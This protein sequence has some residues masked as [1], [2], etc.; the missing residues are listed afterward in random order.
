MRHHFSHY[1]SMGIY[2]AQG[3]TTPGVGYDQ[4]KILI[5]LK[6]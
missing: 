4:A 6:P 5:H 2:F 3:H 1:K